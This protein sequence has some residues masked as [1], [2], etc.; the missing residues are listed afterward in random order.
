MSPGS[1]LAG[2]ALADQADEIARSSLHGADEHRQPKFALRDQ[3][4]G[5]AVVDA[6]GAVVGLRDDGR[7]R[8]AREGDVHLVADLPQARLDDGEREGI[9]GGSAVIVCLH[10]RG[11]SQLRLRDLGLERVEP[12][13][14]LAMSSSCRS[15]SARYCECSPIVMVT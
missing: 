12:L 4:A 3:R 10:D 5:V 1:G 13:L 11:Q 8:R 14:D 2:L 9:D 7:E 6:V 15:T